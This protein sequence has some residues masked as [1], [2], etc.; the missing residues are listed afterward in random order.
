MAHCTG[1]SNRNAAAVRA[2]ALAAATLLG[3]GCGDKDGDDTGGDTADTAD[4]GSSGGSDYAAMD[5]G[6]EMA[7]PD[8]GYG[9]DPAD[10]GSSTI[11]K[12]P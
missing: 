12:R 7:T 3:I 1:C 8:G 2:A 6:P 4:G 10:Q 11:T 9:Y 5:A